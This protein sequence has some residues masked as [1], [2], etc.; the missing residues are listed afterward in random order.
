MVVVLIT[1]QSLLF[2]IA[3]AVNLVLWS[4]SRVV[5]VFAGGCAVQVDGGGCAGDGVGVG[6]GDFCAWWWW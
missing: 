2:L 4:L 5:L 1:R 3:V 6:A